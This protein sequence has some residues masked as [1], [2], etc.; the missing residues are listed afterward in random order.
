MNRIALLIWTLITAS[1]NALS[2][3]SPECT[4]SVRGTVKDLH[5]KEALAYATVLI[6]GTGQ[7]TTTDLDGYFLLEHICEKEFDMVFSYVGYKSV[8][9]HHD[10]HHPTIEVLLVPETTLLESII[11]EAERHG[12]DLASGSSQ[13]LNLRQLPTTATESLGEAVSRIAGVSTVSAG[14]NVVKP[15]I[16]G[17]HSNRILIIN[18]G[19]RHEYQNWGSDHAPE[20]DPSLAGELE[21]IKGAATVRFGPDA[22]GGVILIRGPEMELSGPFK[23]DVKITG[24]SNGRSGE[25]FMQL[26]KG[27]RWISGILSGSLLKQG[28]LHAPDYQLT[29]TGKRESS[30]AGGLRLHP[31]PELDIEGHYRHFDQELGILRGSVNSSLEDLLL[32]LEA[33]IPNFTA[34]FSYDITTPKQ[35]V[36]HDFYKTSARWVGRRQS[37]QLQYGHQ[38]NKRKEYDVRKGND[39]EIPNIDLELRTD[40]IDGEWRHPALGVWHGKL[41]FQWSHQSNDNNAGTNTIPFIPNYDQ[42]RWGIYLIEMF[43]FDRDLFEIG[44]RYDKQEATIVGRQPNNLIYRNDLT[45]Q[46]LSGTIGYKRT[47]NDASTWRSNFG[48][49]W[50]PPN[51]AELYRFGRHLS[52]IEYGLWRYEINEK[53]DFI[54]TQKI[55]TEEDKPV[56]NEVGYKWINTFEFD[57]QK[58]Q[59]EITAYINYI[60]NYIYAKPAGLTRTVRGATPF[61]IYDQTNALLWGVD[62]TLEWDHHKRWHS[63]ITASYLWSQQVPEKDHFVGQPPARISWDLKYHGGKLGFL[64]DH[65]VGLHLGYTFKQWQL[66]R[67]LT[68]SELLN[69]YQTDIDLFVNNAADFDIAQPPEG[70]LMTNLYW[71]SHLKNFTI[72]LEVRNLLNIHYRN[73]TDRLRYFTD[74]LGRNFILSVAYGW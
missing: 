67:T 5:T 38:I 4:F 48:T 72:H 66:P 58:T 2:Q 50:R 13:K 1:F 64:Q 40:I 27:N 20:I 54:S 36:S 53:T 44:L 65:N 9:H 62:F 26:Q 31:L 41:G 14:Q 17:L 45:F 49:A 3:V 34:P 12:G 19:L 73:Y 69:A 39:L 71:Q 60:E 16:H 35:G 52:F 59:G 15:V 37:F 46:N 57:H 32:A 68:I 74:D 8:E 55:L 70:Y 56:K 61:F 30:Y 21:V 42:D 10:Y 7:G 43:E 29:N 51:I 47:I 25:G 28:D 22:L 18:E 11:I 6:K 23:G 33:D 24:K 63:D